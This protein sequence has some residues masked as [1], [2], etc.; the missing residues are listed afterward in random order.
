MAGFMSHLDVSSQRLSEKSNQPPQAGGCRGEGGDFSVWTSHCF[1]LMRSSSL[2]SLSVF[3]THIRRCFETIFSI[4]FFSARLPL[5]ASHFVPKSVR[6][7]RNCSGCSSKRTVPDGT[8]STGFTVLCRPVGL[9]HLPFLVAV[10]PCFCCCR[11]SIHIEIL[12]WNKP[13]Q[14]MCS[15]QVIH[16]LNTSGYQSLKEKMAYSS[17]TSITMATQCLLLVTVW[18]VTMIL[19]SIWKGYFIVFEFFIK[20]ITFSSLSALLKLCCVLC[21]CC[22]SLLYNCVS[23]SDWF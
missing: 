12:T 3:Y 19:I 14:N 9:L 1:S 13:L 5:P 21:N 23:A 10:F 16:K 8:A 2:E 6:A 15:F 17:L 7:H 18:K 11:A 20:V 4:A 22:F